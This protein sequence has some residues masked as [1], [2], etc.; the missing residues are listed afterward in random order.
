MSS[1]NVPVTPD[2]KQRMKL[3]A[4]KYGMRTS[5]LVRDLLENIL[6]IDPTLPPNDFV[7]KTSIET[8]LHNYAPIRTTIPY[9]AS[10]LNMRF[11]D[12]HVIDLQGNRVKIENFPEHGLLCTIYM[13]NQIYRAYKRTK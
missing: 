10:I 11:D 12:G 3:T 13:F 8:L 4:E 5:D 6:P 9:V 2:L 7:E 1:I